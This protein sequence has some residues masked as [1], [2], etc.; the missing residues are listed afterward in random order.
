[1]A[2]PDVTWSPS[3]WRQPVPPSTSALA[4]VVG[5]VADRTAAAGSGRLRIAIDGLTAAGKTSFGHAL[6]LAV[7]AR[8]RPALRA[9]L[10]DFKRPWADRH[11]YD[12]TSGEGYYRNAWDH[13][14]TW[15]LLLGPAAPGGAGSVALCSID[16]LAQIDRSSVLTA[17]SPH[18][19]LVVD[20]VFALRPELDAA[21]DLRIWLE[22]SE[23]LSVRRGGARDGEREGSTE[24]AEA[25]HRERYLAAERIYRAEVDPVARADVVIDTTDLVHPVVVRGA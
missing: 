22:V 9:S 11:R 5:R 17:M 18:A 14:A 13:D 12:R 15:R 4:A 24:A 10:D 20:G 16:A 23:E 7:V 19:V 8:G 21:W 6:A 1:M 25:L 3:S 2:G